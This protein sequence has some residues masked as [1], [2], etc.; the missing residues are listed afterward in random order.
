MF[1]ETFARLF[2]RNISRNYTNRIHVAKKVNFSSKLANFSILRAFLPERWVRSQRKPID[3]EEHFS[4]FAFSRLRQMLRRAPT[5]VTLSKMIA[6][7]HNA[8]QTTRRT[9]IRKSRLYSKTIYLHAKKVAQP[10]VSLTTKIRK[11]RSL[12]LSLR[13]KSSLEKRAC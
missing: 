7:P 10:T 6:R 4:A 8:R 1:H 2:T 11:N 12:L 3:L 5:T 13:E 9:E